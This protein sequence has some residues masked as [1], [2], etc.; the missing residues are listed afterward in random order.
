MDTNEEFPEDFEDMVMEVEPEYWQDQVAIFYLDAYEQ[1]ERS[2]TNMTGHKET[3]PEEEGFYTESYR[4]GTL[5]PE[6]IHYLNELIPM[7][8]FEEDYILPA[9]EMEDGNF[10]VSAS[11]LYPLLDRAVKDFFFATCKKMENEGLLE[12]VWKDGDFY[13]RRVGADSQ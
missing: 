13:Y 9:T 11:N 5:D 4:N 1:F 8:R 12:L 2:L 7:E 3:L 6:I 10:I